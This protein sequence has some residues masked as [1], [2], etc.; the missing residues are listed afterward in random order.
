MQAPHAGG[1][2]LFFSSLHDVLLAA[3]YWTSHL[4]DG[5]FIG[6]MTAIDA[7]VVLI[8]P[9]HH[10]SEIFA[11]AIVPTTQVLP[12]DGILKIMIHGLCSECQEELGHTSSTVILMW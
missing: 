11:N 10:E 2:E 8:R 5:L 3:S 4:G 1:A 12:I 6:S 7:G 9:V